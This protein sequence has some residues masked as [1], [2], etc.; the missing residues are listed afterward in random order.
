MKTIQI[1]KIKDYWKNHELYCDKILNL[2]YA[3]RSGDTERV[4]NF[5]LGCLN[6]QAGEEFDYKI[7]D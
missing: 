6:R 3:R 7:I 4:S 5:V 1:T 2:R